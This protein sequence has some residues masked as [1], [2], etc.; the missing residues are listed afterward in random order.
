MPP[1]LLNQ[2]LASSSNYGCS[3]IRCLLNCWCQ[4]ADHPTW[5]DR[6]RFG[7]SGA[8]TTFNFLDH[9][10]ACIDDRPRAIFISSVVDVHAVARG[11]HSPRRAASHVAEAPG[12]VITHHTGHVLHDVDTLPAIVGRSRTL[13]PGRIVPIEWTDVASTVFPPQSFTSTFW[14]SR[15]P[16]A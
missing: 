6:E 11:I 4:P 10:G 8:T 1:W 14:A 3:R 16:G 13:Y 2:S 7:V 12:R 15:Q 5:P 9:V